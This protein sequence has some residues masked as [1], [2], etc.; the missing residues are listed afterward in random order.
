MQQI[1]SNFNKILNDLIG[2]ASVCLGVSGGSD[3]T[4]MLYLVK[5]YKDIY[6]NEVL[7]V[8]IDHMLR[9]ESKAEA[10]AVSRMCEKLGLNH[11]TIDWLHDKLPTG[12]I[13]ILARNARYDLLMNACINNGIKYLLVAHNFDEQLET[14]FIRKDMHSEERGLAC[15]SLK[16]TIANDIVIIRPC[17]TFSKQEL[18]KYL[19]SKHVSWFEDSMN[20]DSKFTRIKYRKQIKLFSDEERSQ[21]GAKIRA[22]GNERRKI[23]ILS[24]KFL[25]T[26]DIVKNDG[27][28]ELP[29]N[30]FEKLDLRVQRDVLK[31]LIKCVGR[32]MYAVSDTVC[33]LFINSN[34]TYSHSKIVMK[35]N[36]NNIIIYYENRNIEPTMHMNAGDEMVWNNRF[37]I[38]SFI[39]GL[40]VQSFGQYRRVENLPSYIAASLPE[41]IENDKTVHIG[42]QNNASLG[43]LCNFMTTPDLYDVFLPF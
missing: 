5:Q 21:L 35:K 18:Q 2:T 14:Y 20:E 40:A 25:K 34:N 32:R 6:H 31:R 30:E 15:M 28:A 38:R 16:R 37:K 27:F 23:E 17:L 10:A 24:T 41:F 26:Y 39:N 42:N 4:A 36:K 7:V 29:R 11:L 8:T 3:S 1:E 33:D 19:I 43:F 22:F 9:T 12:K 13:E